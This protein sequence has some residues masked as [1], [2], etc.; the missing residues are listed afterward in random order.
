MC[1]FFRLQVYERVG[2]S[3]AEEY[4]R[5]GKSVISV[6]KKAQ[7]NWQMNFMAVKMSRKRS[8]VVIYSYLKDDVVTAM[9]RNAKF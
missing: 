2:I 3:L 8:G 6:C 5:V 7:K 9:K 4:D 1:Y